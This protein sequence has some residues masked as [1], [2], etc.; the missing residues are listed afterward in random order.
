MIEIAIGKGN[1]SVSAIAKGTPIAIEIWIVNET[2]AIQCRL[3]PLFPGQHPV[4]P[5]WM[6]FPSQNYWTQTNRDGNR[7]YPWYG[8]LCRA[9]ITVE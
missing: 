1:A 9:D 4:H 2:A 3:V 7:H 6:D 5:G 8:G